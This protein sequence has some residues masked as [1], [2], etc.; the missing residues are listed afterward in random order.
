MPRSRP[1]TTMNVY[2]SQ[3]Y[4]F[5]GVLI[6]QHELFAPFPAIPRQS[7]LKAP[8]CI[9]PTIPL[10]TLHLQKPLKLKVDVSGAP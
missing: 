1:K 8:E 4:K 3:Q 6:L 10:A 9:I 2:D 5:S 7:M